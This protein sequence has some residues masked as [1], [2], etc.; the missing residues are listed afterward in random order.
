MYHSSD[1]ERL[2]P[3]LQISCYHIFMHTY[4]Q[5]II[6]AN[7]K[8]N[9]T[10][11]EAMSWMNVV[12]PVSKNSQHTL[13]LCPPSVFLA[14]LNDLIQQHKFSIQLGVQ[15]LSQFPAG[16]Y[17][18]AIN[19]RNLESLGVKYALLGHS[20][21]RRYFHETVQEIANKV[22]L[23]VDAGITP[24]VC[25]RIEDI[26]AQAAS[27]TMEMRKKIIV[28]YETVGHIGTGEVEKLDQVLTSVYEIHKTFE[29]KVPVL[30]GG[31]VSEATQEQFMREEMLAGIGVGSKSLDADDFGKIIG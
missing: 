11:N 30:Y 25:L 17:T 8:S 29:L 23:A 9:K 26:P 7:W 16:A 1:D 6:L 2:S 21:R 18:G 3:V 10:L 13:I 27:L 28:L 12:G 4:A 24:I 14:P 15:D 5:K 31:S 20:E 22:E 19:T